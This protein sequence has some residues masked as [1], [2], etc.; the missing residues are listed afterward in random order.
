MF[1]PSEWTSLKELQFK[2]PQMRTKKRTTKQRYFKHVRSKQHARAV[3][4][5]LARKTVQAALGG[6]PALQRE[7]CRAPVCDCQIVSSE[8]YHL[9]SSDIPTCESPPF[10]VDLAIHTRH[11]TSAGVMRP[12]PCDISDTSIEVSPSLLPRKK[13]CDITGYPVCV[14]S[15]RLS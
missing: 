7:S 1:V 4:G 12:F 10:A 14:A 5:G 2:P 9:V 8:N 11:P 3:G 13:Y 6:W 15:D